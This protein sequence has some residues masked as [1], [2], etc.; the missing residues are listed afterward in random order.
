[1][2]DDDSRLAFWTSTDLSTLSINDLEAII[3]N[4]NAKEAGEKMTLGGKKDVLVERLENHKKAV[5]LYTKPAMMGDADAQYSL[6]L[7]YAN[8]GGVPQDFEQAAT[9]YRKAAA[10]G[11]SGIIHNLNAEVCCQVLLTGLI[12]RR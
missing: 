11:H 10:Q 7:C 12:Q 4:E 3:R 1:M 6:G 5:A 2:I 8:G 9:W